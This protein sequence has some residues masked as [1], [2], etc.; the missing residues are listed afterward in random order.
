MLSDALHHL[1]N[2]LAL[3]LDPA[4]WPLCGT[5]R[6]KLFRRILKDY[7]FLDANKQHNGISPDQGNNERR[8]IL[9]ALY[10]EAENFY[11]QK[12]AFT[13]QLF[14]GLA[15]TKKARSA[16]AVKYINVLYCCSS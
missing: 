8:E 3:L 12:A 13:Q 9:L 5:T 10:E 7:T 4:N 2:D 11:N 14:E 1:W 16:Q 15:V 6:K